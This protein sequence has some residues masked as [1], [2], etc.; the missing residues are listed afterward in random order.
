M[1]GRPLIVVP[2]LAETTGSIAVSLEAKQFGLKR[3]VRV[4]E[5]RQ[6]C[7]EVVVVEARPELYI[8]YHRRLREI[9]E[10]LVPVLGEYTLHC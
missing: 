2:I 6:Q 10:T 5:A 8:Q 1:R 9:V 3:N 4:A 7:P